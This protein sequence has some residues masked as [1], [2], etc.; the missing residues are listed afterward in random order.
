[1]LVEDCYVHDNGGD[2]I[3]LNSRDRDGHAQGVI[4][5]RNRVVRNHLNGIKLWA[6]G[7]IE[8]NIVWGQGNSAIWAGTFHSNL[9][10]INNTVAYNMWDAS[11]SERNWAFV[12][13]YPEE[14]DEPQVDLLLVN[15]IFAFNVGPQVGDPT[16]LYLGSG[17]N[18]TE[19]HN[20][21]F[22]RVDEEI[23]A[24]FLGFEVSRQS[25]AEGNWQDRSGQGSDDLAV[26]PL[27]LSSFPDVNLQLQPGSPAID[28]GD[29]R[30]CPSTD[31]FGISRP[32]DGEGDGQAACDIGA[33][34]V[35]G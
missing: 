17:V 4:V 15:N 20:L 34:E 1:V 31:A 22:S 30:V 8:N 28:A 9:E 32:V 16:G 29:Q 5:R 2:G 7:R 11:F 12:V 19:H 26:D 33:I 27:F 24:E 23:T 21:Y 35:E 10:V 14:I 6:G 13:G 3:D 25:I 18:L